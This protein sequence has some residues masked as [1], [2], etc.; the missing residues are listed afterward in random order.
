[1]TPDPISDD[2]RAAL[3]DAI[4][5]GEL[6]E[7]LAAL[8]ASGVEPL[9]FKGAA[10]AHTHYR[11]PWQRPRLDADVLIAAAHRQRAFEIL[12]ALGYSQPPMTAGDLVSYQTM[13]V[14]TNAT[15]RE[16]V[17]DL[18]W[19]IS[20][21]QMTAHALTHAELVARS[22]RIVVDGRSMRVPSSV[23]ALVIACLHR[24]AHHA[25][26]E[27]PIWIYDIHLIA[28]SLNTAQW[29]A[30]ID[31]AVSR[32]LA[33]ICA[34]GLSLA[35]RWFQ[36]RLPDDVIDRLATSAE[37]SSIL[38]KRD[39]PQIQRLIADLRVLGPRKGA[40]LLREHLFPP[41]AY[42][43]GKYG[44]RSRAL[45]PAFYAYRIVAGSSKWL[46]PRTKD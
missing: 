18:H 4:A 40:R 32:R 23:D 3:L 27:I 15:G 30:F 12:F 17:I 6:T 2:R 28:E 25:D 21:P 31:L 26:A 38:L 37:P 1:M 11:Q 29:T 36:T 46:R 42:V 44:V 13:F 24:V 7:A 19:Q 41:S 14:R 34:R 35:K 33:A 22:D 45:L 10:L 5:V 16:H 43:K 9:V 8:D 20:N 39:L